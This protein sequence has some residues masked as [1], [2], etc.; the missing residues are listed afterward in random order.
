MQTYKKPM[1]RKK[2]LVDQTLNLQRQDIEL[3]NRIQ[4]TS[5]EY[6]YLYPSLDDPNFNVSIASRK[7]FTI[8]GTKDRRIKVI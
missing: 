8:L 4:A 2:K 1:T 3:Q 6:S 7:D 5:G